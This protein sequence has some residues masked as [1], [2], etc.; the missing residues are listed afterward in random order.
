MRSPRRRRVHPTAMAPSRSMA[1]DPHPPS[2][3]AKSRRL[4]DGGAGG[5][6]VFDRLPDDVV[7][8]V[9]A[10]LAAAAASPADIASAALAC[11][12]FRELAAH[13]AVLSRASAAAVAVRWAAW[14]ETAQRFLRRCA[15]AGSLHA[16]YFLG[17]VRFYCLGSRATGAALLARAAGGGHAP[18]LYA[19]AVMQ[20]NGSGGGKGDKDPRAGVA[21]CARAAWLGHTP[22]LRELGHCLQDGYGAR[23]DPAAGRRLLLHAAAREHLSWKH[24]HRHH[25]HSGGGHGHDDGSAAEDAASRFMV[26]CWDSHSSKTAARG[27]LPGHHADAADDDD[28]RLCSHA[29]CGRRE[30]RRHEFRRCSV[31]GAANYCS[32]ACQALDWKRAHRAQCAAARWLAAGDAH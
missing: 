23:R 30:T 10:R 25:H 22:A 1:T 20:F 7:V 9:L 3:A 26:D 32:R 18:A 16:C 19:L 27:C 28:L 6:D 13:P 24:K 31:C 8:T 14:S 2:P 12:R 21:L 4:A 5:V 29:R 15:A 11:R 17:M